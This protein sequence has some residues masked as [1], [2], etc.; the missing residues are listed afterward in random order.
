MRSCVMTRLLNGVNTPLGLTRHRS[1]R[2]NYG[3]T[4]STGLFLSDYARELNCTMSLSCLV[5]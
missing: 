3:A 4:G 1:L 5:R 2:Q